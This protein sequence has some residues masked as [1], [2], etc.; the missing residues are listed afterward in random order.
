MAFPKF[1]PR[2]FLLVCIPACSIAGSSDTITSGSMSLMET[3]HAIC[4]DGALNEASVGRT[5][6]PMIIVYEESF[7]PRLPIVGSR[8]VVPPEYR[9]QIIDNSAAPIWGEFEKPL[10]RSVSIERGNNDPNS[11]G[12]EFAKIW[13]VEA[14]VVPSVNAL[15]LIQT[16]DGKRSDSLMDRSVDLDDI[17]YRMTFD[18]VRTLLRERYG[19]QDHGYTMR[20]NPNHPGSFL[21]RDCSD[22]VV[23]D[24]EAGQ[25]VNIRDLAL[26][27][28]AAAARE[29]GE[30][31]VARF[32]SF[33]DGTWAIGR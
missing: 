1:F 11:I 16:R 7:E 27:L 20:N 3:L 18:Q 4:R 2:L 13:E 25:E 31:Y 8:S 17:G 32:I 5:G 30:S 23:W 33:Q 24:G 12:R 28:L 22:E 6:Q 9:N 15:V 29:K 10:R 14:I 26:A 19:M 21:C